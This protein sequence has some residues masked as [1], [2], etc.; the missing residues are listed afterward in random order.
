MQNKLFIDGKFV[1]A[2]AGG[3]IDVLNPYDGALITAIAAAEADE[4]VKGGGRDPVY[5]VESFVSEVCRLSRTR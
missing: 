2:A 5:A 1:D 4:A 3:T